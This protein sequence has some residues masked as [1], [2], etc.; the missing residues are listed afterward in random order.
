MAT[1]YSK[2]GLTY[3]DVILRPQYSEI[4]SRKDIDLTTE[5]APGVQIKT[6]IVAANMDTVISPELCIELSRLGGLAW[7]HQFGSIEEELKVLKAV[8]AKGERVGCTISATND[9]IERAKVMIDNGADIILI[10]TPHA[11]SYMGI[12]AVKN[13]RKHFGKFPLIA[14]TVAT[15]EGALDLIKAGAD[16]LKVG[17]GAGAACLTRVNAG[18]GM[19]QLSAVMECSEICKKEGKSLIADAGI[20]Y[21]GSLAKAIAAGG[22]AGMMGSVL[23]GTLESP[24]KLVEKDGKKF[25]VYY[26]SASASGKKYRATHDPNHKKPATEFIEGGEGLVPYHGTL[27]EVITKYT[28]GLRSAMSYTGARN[29]KEFQEKAIFIELTQSGI[30]ENFAHGMV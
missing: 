30:Q 16:G 13:F 27:E 17:I 3:D 10:D 9:Y 15:K 2:K 22:H 18:S 8:K 25:K 24:S 1:I 5:L 23:T 20:K 7:N 21:P 28:M 6:P 19:P 4:I 11:H 26:G 14:G 12:E 29:I